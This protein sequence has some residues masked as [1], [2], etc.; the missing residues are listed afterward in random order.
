[1]IAIASLYADPLH[2]GHLDYLEAAKGTYGYLVAIVNNDI[3]AAL[4][5]GRAFMREQDRLRIVSA[6]RCVDRAVLS[7]DQDR[8]VCR[9]LESIARECPS[10]YVFC[11]GG[12]VTSALEADLCKQLGIR[13]AYGV[14]GDKVE[15]SSGLL[16]RASQH[17]HIRL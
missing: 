15:S 2:S 14:G 10:W 16:E 3:Q 8:S 6:L 1:M 7:I 9:T 4:K 12:D 17:L 13:M 11:N 5:K